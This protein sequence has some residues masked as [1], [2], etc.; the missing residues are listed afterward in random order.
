[1]P[2]RIVVTLRPEARASLAAV[3]ERLSDG[4]GMRVGALF[5]RQGVVVG[6]VEGEIEVGRIGAMPDVV[7]VR[8]QATFAKPGPARGGR[9]ASAA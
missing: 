4:A 6:E 3:A 8:E 5:T 1:M 9:P 7:G 2:K